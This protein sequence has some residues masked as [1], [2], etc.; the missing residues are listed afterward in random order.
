MFRTNNKK[1]WN[2]FEFNERV[3]YLKLSCLLFIVIVCNGDDGSCPEICQCFHFWKNF[4][5][6]CANKFIKKIPMDINPEV[7]NNTLCQN[8][9]KFQLNF[10]TF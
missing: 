7:G 5:I 8:L 3:F 6:N 2:H 1:S 4:R 10:N 9:K